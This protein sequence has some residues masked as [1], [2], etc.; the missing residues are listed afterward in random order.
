[1]SICV[2]YIRFHAALSAQGI[3][4]SQL[5]YRSPFQ[6]YLAWVGLGFF[7]LVTL[8][9]G[10]DSIAGGWN[11]QAFL[12]SYIG[13][14]IFFG[15]FTL[16][17]VVKKTTWIKSDQADL[18]TGKAALDMVEWPERKPRNWAERVWFWIA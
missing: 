18:L 2:A 4:R 12:T 15:L 14:P 7:A 1:M 17:K 6:P 5:Y 13:F 10:W 16:W 11:Y 8:F 9:N 3:D